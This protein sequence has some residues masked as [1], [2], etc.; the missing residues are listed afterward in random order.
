MEETKNT[1]RNQR[2]NGRNQ[3]NKLG[4]NQ[5]MQETVDLSELSLE[6]N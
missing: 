2:K 3:K 4:R 6:S 5:N 1:E